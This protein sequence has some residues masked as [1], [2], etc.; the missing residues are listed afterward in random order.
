MN[1]QLEEKV[2][3]ASKVIYQ[4]LVVVVPSIYY[5]KGQVLS[6]YHKYNANFVYTSFKL[7]INKPIKLHRF[8]YI[9]L[10]LVIIQL[11]FYKKLIVLIRFKSYFEFFFDEI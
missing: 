1:R 2:L 7:N 10:Q 6:A 4:S 11:K 9:I 8:I 3:K 5:D